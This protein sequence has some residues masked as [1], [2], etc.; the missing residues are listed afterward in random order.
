MTIMLFGAVGTLI[1]CSIISLGTGRNS[2]PAVIYLSVMLSYFMEVKH[3][4]L[5][6]EDFCVQ[7]LPQCFFY[8][9][10]CM[11][12][13]ARFAS[14]C[15][16]V[17]SLMVLNHSFAPPVNFN[18]CH[19]PMIFQKIGK[20]IASPCIIRMPLTLKLLSVHPEIFYG[21]QS[22]SITKRWNNIPFTF[23]H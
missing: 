16:L 18:L 15:L 5:D 21:F 8:N 20:Y 13:W 7:R 1:S 19:Q 11:D 3:Q 9:G 17:S 23:F 10:K 6:L 2:R 4:D 22:K 14:L 12:G